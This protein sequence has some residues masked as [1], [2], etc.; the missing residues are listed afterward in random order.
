MEKVEMT[1]LGLYGDKIAKKMPP[2]PFFFRGNSGA[3]WEAVGFENQPPPVGGLARVMHNGE[4]MVR[5]QVVKDGRIGYMDTLHV[6][7][8]LAMYG[9]F[10]KDG[11]Q[12]KLGYLDDEK[13][14]KNRALSRARGLVPDWAQH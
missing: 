14:T 9:E 8:L 10:D 1:G 12:I 3:L 13:A 11:K 5:A 7:Q 6:D 4:P 2:F